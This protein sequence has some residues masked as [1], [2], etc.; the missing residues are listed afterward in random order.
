MKRL[1]RNPITWVDSRGQVV[2]VKGSRKNQTER[3][4]A[5]ELEATKDLLSGT[6]TRA[7]GKVFYAPFHIANTQAQLRSEAE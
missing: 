5:A 7:D 2:Y 4:T 6:V 3:L 1:V